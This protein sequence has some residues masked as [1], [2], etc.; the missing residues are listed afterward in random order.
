MTPQGPLCTVCIGH[1]SPFPT[2]M[3]RIPPEDLLLSHFPALNPKE[4]GPSCIQAVTA[5]WKQRVPGQD[6]V[7]RC[8][9]EALCLGF[10]QGLLLQAITQLH[11]SLAVRHQQL[12]E[13]PPLPPEAEGFCVLQSTLSL[14]Y[15][16]EDTPQ[17]FKRKS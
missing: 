3:E 17:I 7:Q 2:V 1:S 4:A 11:R 10:S 15:L 12:A 9:K 13:F 5:E 6:W 8:R 16:G 14:Q